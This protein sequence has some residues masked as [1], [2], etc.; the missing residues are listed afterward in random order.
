[1]QNENTGVK[2]NTK[3]MKP[4]YFNIHNEKE[5]D[6]FEWVNNRFSTFGG[7]VKDL[8]YTQMMLEKEGKTLRLE[9]CLLEKESK[10]LEGQITINEAF[11]NTNANEEVSTDVEI[12][13]VIN[14][15]C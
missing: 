9:N 10:K 2:E 8:L 1:M 6:L 11:Q 15:D 3:K 7:L 14:Y 4:V 13:D 12:E 5:K